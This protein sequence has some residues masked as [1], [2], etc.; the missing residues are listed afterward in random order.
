MYL[1]YRCND[2][3]VCS[4]LCC[5]LWYIVAQVFVSIRSL[6][7]TSSVDFEMFPVV[8]HVWACFQ[9]FISGFLCICYTYAILAYF[10]FYRASS[11]RYNFFLLATIATSLKTKSVF[12][13]IVRIKHLHE[14]TGTF[15]W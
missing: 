9:V 10:T 11:S 13:L 5:I 12:I 8:V 7:L 15:R 1:V 2:K 4:R 14:M 3:N 6:V